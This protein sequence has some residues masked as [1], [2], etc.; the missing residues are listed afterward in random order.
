MDKSGI[1]GS[2]K[3]GYGQIR[4]IKGKYAQIRVIKPKYSQIVVNIGK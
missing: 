2:N 3:G 1:L 4:V